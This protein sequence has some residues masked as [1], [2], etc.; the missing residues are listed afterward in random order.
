MNIVAENKILLTPLDAEEKTKSG[1]Y[2]PNQAKTKP[3]KGQV[4]ALGEG[5]TGVNLGDI[6]HFSPY[7]PEPVEVGG[8][9]YE[10]IDWADILLIERA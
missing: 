9:L 2:T 4:V 10:I 7:K 1:F 6:I 3:S 8:T 5:V